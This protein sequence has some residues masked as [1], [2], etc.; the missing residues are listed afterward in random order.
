M[1][2]SGVAALG[3][4]GDKIED[5]YGPVLSRRSHDDGS[6]DIVYQKDRYLITVTF[7][8]GVSVAEEYSRADRR[9]LSEKEIAKFLK[10]NGGR[11]LTVTRAKGALKVR[12]K[13]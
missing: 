2:G 4:G 13:N 8:R 11:G 7:N 9:D 6:V 12:I 5:S 10:M 3:D 1:A